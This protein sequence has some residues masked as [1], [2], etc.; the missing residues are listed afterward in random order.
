MVDGR[1]GVGEAHKC[2]KVKEDIAFPRRPG[3]TPCTS[4]TIDSFSEE[5]EWFVVAAVFVFCNDVWRGMRFM[6]AET[7]SEVGCTV[8]DDDVVC[9]ALVVEGWWG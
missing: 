5:E 9:D 4:L 1:G 8:V 3:L 7:P 2:I 6:L